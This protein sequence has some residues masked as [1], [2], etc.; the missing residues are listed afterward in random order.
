MSEPFQPTSHTTIPFGEGAIERVFDN[1]LR[2]DPQMRHFSVLVVRKP[3]S[4]DAYARLDELPYDSELRPPVTLPMPSSDGHSGEIPA[5]V[6]YFNDRNAPDVSHFV[7]SLHHSI[8][9]AAH[10]YTYAILVRFNPGYRKRNIVPGINPPRLFP[11]APH[12]PSC[13]LLAASGNRLAFFSPADAT[14]YIHTCQRLLHFDAKTTM[15]VPVGALLPYLSAPR[16]LLDTAWEGN[17]TIGAPD[18]ATS[19]WE[20]RIRST[21]VSIPSRPDRIFDVHAFE[22]FKRV[23]S[24]AYLAWIEDG[25]EYKIA[26][27]GAFTHRFGRRQTYMRSRYPRLRDWLNYAIRGPASQTAPSWT[28]VS[29]RRPEQIAELI[30][31]EEE[32]PAPEGT[33][34][35]PND[36]I[37]EWTT[38][39]Y[40]NWL[41]AAIMETTFYLRTFFQMNGKSANSNPAAV[42]AE[43]HELLINQGL[44]RAMLA[45]VGDI[46]TEII[47][48]QSNA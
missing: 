15:G 5:S 27:G 25:V 43:V 41:S 23:T 3:P 14:R 1:L 8:H 9:G 36:E 7:H 12:S 48:A 31:Q 47:V 35:L 19:E 29:P 33:L 18:E 42:D 46:P 40:P 38:I 24:N 44:L 16:H 45:L 2:F 6:A 26:P 20:A 17:L 34:C 32:A 28:P 13:C 4:E 22:E 37:D 10:Y 39:Y 11:Y 21:G 30:L